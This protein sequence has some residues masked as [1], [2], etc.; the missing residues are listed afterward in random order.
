MARTTMGAV[1]RFVASGDV[2]DPVAVVDGC[3]ISP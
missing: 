1:R 2:G 3:R